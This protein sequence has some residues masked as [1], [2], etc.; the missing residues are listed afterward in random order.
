MIVTLASTDYHILEV[1]FNVVIDP[2]TCDCSLLDW[3]AP[4]A[5]QLVT[6]RLKE[7]PDSITIDH[8]LVNEASK[9]AFPA[10]RSC[11]R[12][13][14][15]SPAPSCDETTVIT[16]VRVSVSQGDDLPYFLEW[17]A[18]NDIIT[19]NSILPEEEL[20]WEMV[21]THSTVDEG[22]LVITTVEIVIDACVITD[23]DL[24]DQPTTTEYLIFA[25]SDLEIDLSTPG[26]Q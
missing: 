16:D 25:L 4:A 18:P 3:D 12:D 17:T 11:Y 9:S 19:V 8:Y 13:D 10:I 1:P 21:I 7:A 14:L 22:D 15:P 20:T 23:I 26:F 24:P 2:A 5:Q 6:T